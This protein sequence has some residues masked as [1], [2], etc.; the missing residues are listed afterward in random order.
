MMNAALSHLKRQ[1][2]LG[3]NHSQG[4]PGKLPYGKGFSE[5]DCVHEQL[6]RRIL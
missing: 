6:L 2:S 5:V 4:M 3:L 1:R